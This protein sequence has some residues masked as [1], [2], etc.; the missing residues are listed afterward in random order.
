MNCML[1]RGAYSTL[2]PGL[3]ACRIWPLPAWDE[4]RVRK[5]GG[6]PTRTPYMNG[7]LLMD[8]YRTD[9]PG[10]GACRIWPLPA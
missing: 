5:G 10:L 2:E 4:V 1:C 9:A 6:Q 8:S 7:M 3:G